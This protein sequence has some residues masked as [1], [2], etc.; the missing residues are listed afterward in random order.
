[1]YLRVIP[2]SLAPR[3]EARRP[4]QHIGEVL[5][6]RAET[7]QGTYLASAKTR[8]EAMTLG[9]RALMTL[10][11]QVSRATARAKA[12]DERDAQFEQEIDRV[13]AESVR[14]T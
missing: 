3:E 14:S 5:S 1:M 12:S 11:S 7:L 10:G 13:F 4:F 2:V 8:S 6:Y 9:L